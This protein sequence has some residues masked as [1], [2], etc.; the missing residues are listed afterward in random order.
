[1]TQDR[2]GSLTRLLQIKYGSLR[3]G[4]LMQPAVAAHVAGW[5]MQQRGARAPYNGHI[6]EPHTLMQPA[7]AHTD[8]GTRA[9]LY[10]RTRRSTDRE[11]ANYCFFFLSS[12]R[13]AAR[14]RAPPE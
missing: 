5:C 11:R 13:R 1:M 10:N 2:V 7:A 12:P 4:V 8:E 14:E 6:A 3:S 9:G